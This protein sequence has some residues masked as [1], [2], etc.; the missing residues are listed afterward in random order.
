[1]AVNR[2]ILNPLRLPFRHPGNYF[3]K[4]EMA[5][6]HTS[7]VLANF[8]SEKDKNFSN[9]LSID[10]IRRIGQVPEEFIDSLGADR[11]SVTS[12]RVSKIKSTD[13]LIG[14]L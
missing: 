3:Y 13:L 1:M 14:M 12:T 6:C 9:T 5:L 2:R 10:P 4:S 11:Y 7:S 8:I